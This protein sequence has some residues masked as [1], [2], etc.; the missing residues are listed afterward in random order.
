MGIESKQDWTSVSSNKDPQNKIGS[1]S[2][3][4]LCGISQSCSI[5]KY[6]CWF[7]RGLQHMLEAAG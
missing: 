7:H 4:P 2:I 1:M 6:R 5:E 3:C